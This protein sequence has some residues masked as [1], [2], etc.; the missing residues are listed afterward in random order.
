MGKN[1]EQVLSTPQVQFFDVKKFLL[2]VLPTKKAMHHLKVRKKTLMP[3]KI[4]VVLE[5]LKKWHPFL[6]MTSQV[7]VI[8]N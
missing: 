5:N 6:E 2:K 1:I 4:Q 7:E 3:Q 8:N